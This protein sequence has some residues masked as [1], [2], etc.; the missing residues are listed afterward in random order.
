MIQVGRLALVL[1]LFLAVGRARAEAPAPA[2]RLVTLE[3]VVRRA[4]ENP[5]AV[6]AALAT[7]ERTRREEHA[8][9]GAYYPRLTLEG[10]GS[11]D[12]QAQYYAPGQRADG[13][14][15]RTSGTATL[16]YALL[17]RQ[18]GA[19]LK[20]AGAD[21]S[22]QEAQARDAQ[23]SAVEGAVALYY[24]ALAAQELIG[25]AQ[26]T[27]ERRSSQLE[28]IRALSQGGVRPLVDAQRAEIEVVIARTTL[29]VREVDEVALASALAGALGTDPRVPLR[30]APSSAIEGQLFTPARAVAEAIE[31]R[32]DLRASRAAVDASAARDQAARAAR[33]PTLGIYGSGQAGNVKRLD[34]QVLDGTFYGASAGLYLRWAALDASVWRRAEVSSSAILEAERAFDAALLRVQNEAV[35]AAYA[36]QREEAR[37]AQAEQVLAGA[38]VTRKAQ[39]ERYRAGVATL[40]ELLDAEQVEQTARVSRIEAQRDFAVAR[41]RH[42]SACGTL[43]AR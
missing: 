18:R 5:P 35:A 41:A 23:R 27:L 32:P 39:N 30:P 22:A 33:Q 38:E 16:D 11:L 25:D 10:R 24:Q 9:G 43:A 36:A 4:R 37:L 40:L 20:A 29:R 42:A 8:A 14:S 2:G 15:L 19:T 26:L 3:E 21:V 34:G 12:Y 7:L 6:L 13:T 17:D 28:S 1:S 31:H